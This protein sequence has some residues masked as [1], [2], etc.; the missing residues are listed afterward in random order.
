MRN[1][2]VTRGNTKKIFKARS[3]L[4]TRKYTFLS[5]VVNNWNELPE[6]V[7]KAET[8][9]IF[10]SRLDKV[11]KGQAQRYDYKADITTTRNQHLV[12][13]QAIELESQA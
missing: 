2:D 9:P 1:N 5:R 4:N 12:D 6:S 8:I 7:V 11:W 10:E 3:R 13:N